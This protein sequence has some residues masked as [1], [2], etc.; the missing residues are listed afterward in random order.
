MPRA[1]L[2]REGHLVATS[3][4]PNSRP[5]RFRYRRYGTVRL[6]GP[7]VHPSVQLAPRSARRTSRI[8]LEPSA[9][10]MCIRSAFV[11]IPPRLRPL[12]A[13][14]QREAKA[15]LLRLDETCRTA[16]P[17][18]GAPR[19]GPEPFSTSPRMIFACLR[20]SSGVSRPCSPIRVLRER[21]SCSRLGDVAPARHSRKAAMLR[22]SAARPHDGRYPIG[23]SVFARWAGKRRQRWSW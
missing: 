16:R 21:P 2:S 10:K 12:P 20:A 15:T 14:P 22:T 4:R 11:R 13:S 17:A 1:G 6:I 9:G 3:I 19:W 5:P 8:R 23:F 18:C 7:V